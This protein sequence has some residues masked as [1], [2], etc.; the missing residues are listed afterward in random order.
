MKI[1]KNEY[2]KA[3]KIAKRLESDSHFRHKVHKSPRD[4]NRQVY[5]ITITNYQNFE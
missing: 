2:I 1:G 4:Y 3:I 5:K